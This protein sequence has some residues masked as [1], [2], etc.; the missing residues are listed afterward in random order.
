MYEQGLNLGLNHSIYMA[1]TLYNI[2]YEYCFIIKIILIK[3]PIYLPI[4]ITKLEC[5]EKKKNQ[6]SQKISKHL[7]IGIKNRITICLL[8]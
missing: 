6:K 5:H 2:H 7:N 8:N 1:I 3:K 4:K